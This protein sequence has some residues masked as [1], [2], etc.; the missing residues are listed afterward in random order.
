GTL[1]SPNGARVELFNRVGGSADNFAT[2]TFD[3]AAATAITAGTAPFNGSFRPSQA[4]AQLIGE[5]PNGTWH[6]EVQD[7]AAQDTGTI[8]SWSITLTTG[9][10]SRVTDA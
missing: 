6:L 7:V 1:V 4:L 8:N 2:T 9:E 5:S 3:D 10:L